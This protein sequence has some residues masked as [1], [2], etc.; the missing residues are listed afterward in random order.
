MSETGRPQHAAWALAVAIIAVALIVT[1]GALYVFRSARS[2]P[3]E[4]AESGRKAL[5]ELREVAAAFRTGSIT[6]TFRGDATSVA[7]TTRLQFAELRQE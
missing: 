7:G 3:A 2:L 1:G 6:T 4:V 5:S